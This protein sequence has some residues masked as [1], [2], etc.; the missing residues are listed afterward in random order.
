MRKFLSRLL[1]MSM[2]TSMLS[3]M[4]V[5][6]NSAALENNIVNKFIEL[7]D[8]TKVIGAT[9]ADINAVANLLAE[10]MRYQHPN[11]N[12][13]LSKSEFID[14]LKRYMGVADSLTTKVVNQING[15]QAVTI[16]YISTIVMDGKTEVDPAP[17]MRLIEFKDGKIVLVREY[18]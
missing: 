6:F 4:L 13:D 12:A 18:W 3:L 7:T 1:S 15:K 16:A 11:Y 5:L 17:L 10:D 14:G 2:L 9:D 8:K